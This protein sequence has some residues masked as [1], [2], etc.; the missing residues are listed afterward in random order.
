MKQAASKVDWASLQEEG[1]SMLR[2]YIVHGAPT[3]GYSDVYCTKLSCLRVPLL[4][5]AASLF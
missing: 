4:L 2:K 3:C 5:Q 1:P